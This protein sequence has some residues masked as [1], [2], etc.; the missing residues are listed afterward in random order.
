MFLGFSPPCADTQ[1]EH[2][3]AY[4]AEVR[5]SDTEVRVRTPP[6]I[7]LT[8][9]PAVS[10]LSRIGNPIAATLENRSVRWRPD[11]GRIPAATSVP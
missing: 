3:H 9:D 10:S 5:N 2:P 7:N 4:L 11:T 8:A 1:R 6:A